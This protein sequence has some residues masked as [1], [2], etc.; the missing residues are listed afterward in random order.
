[1]IDFDALW[2]LKDSLVQPQTKQTRFSATYSHTDQNGVPWV[3]VAGSEELSPVTGS[4]SATMEQGQTVELETRDGTLYVAGNSSD[5]SQGSLAARAARGALNEGIRTAKVAAAMADSVAKQAK[6]VADAINQHFWADGSGVHV[7]EVGQADFEETPTGRNILMNAYGFLLREAETW[8]A[9]FTEGAT[10]FYDGLG[11]AAANIVAQFGAD[12][13][14]IGRL[15]ESHAEI[16]SNSLQFVD[17]S[18]E[19]FFLV[20]DAV[21]VSEATSL[22][23]I[24]ESTGSSTDN[25]LTLQHA[26][27]RTPV[28]YRTDGMPSAVTSVSGNV[29]TLEFALRPG[30]IAIVPY[31]TTDYHAMNGKTMMLGVNEDVPLAAGA[32]SAS[33]G[34]ENQPSGDK[35]MTVGN[36]CQA[37]DSKT[38]ASGGGCLAA[39]EASVAH[40]LFAKAI[41]IASFAQGG[42][43]IAYG[44]YQHVIGRFNEIDIDGNYVLVIGNGTANNSRSNAYAVG[45]DGTIET[46]RDLD[47][48]T[49][50]DV[51]SSKSSDIN[52]T[53]FKYVQRGQVVSLWIRFQRTTATSAGA[54]ITVGTLSTAYRPLV[55]A[56]APAPAGAGDAYALESGS[57]MY[58]PQSQLAA[59]ANAYVRVTYLV[60]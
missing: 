5:P 23:E 55:E 14:R 7:T 51:L 50:T 48:T 6:R 27:A 12:G 20:N 31:E 35:S 30:S 33:V 15:G 18:G 21:E 3:K 57:V 39:G 59:N 22:V 36:A 58:R 26:P 44:P 24:F 25:T 16:D 13:A 28:I 4:L 46:A 17:E 60:A 9:S 56:A 8:L 1:M 10:A 42:N 40:G 41:G 2:R 32:Y 47:T 38:F 43:A 45:W 49:W 53:G 37:V 11:N 52:I 34:T 29:L 19:P 54:A